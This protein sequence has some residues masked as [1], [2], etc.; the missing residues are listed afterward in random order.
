MS[1]STKT[2]ETKIKNIRAKTGENYGNQIKFIESVLPM[3]YFFLYDFEC[4]SIPVYGKEVKFDARGSLYTHIR[5]GIYLPTAED[6]KKIN[7]HSQNLSEIITKDDNFSLSHMDKIETN[8]FSINTAIHSIKYLSNK[9]PEWAILLAPHYLTIRA[10]ISYNERDALTKRCE[11]LEYIYTKS[12]RA[13]DDK[14]TVMKF[15]DGKNDNNPLEQ[16]YELSC[17]LQNLTKRIFPGFYI[18]EE[19][20]ELF[21]LVTRDPSIKY[22]KIKEYWPKFPEEVKRV[23]PNPYMSIP[24]LLKSNWGK[25]PTAIE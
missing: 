5:D 6:I 11:L 1:S 14:K 15:F 8:D 17:I 3:Y 23:L 24:E 19:I 4:S 25:Q 7:M 20:L 10:T 2:K 16:I 9:I 21:R 13:K 22:Y 18:K 12:I